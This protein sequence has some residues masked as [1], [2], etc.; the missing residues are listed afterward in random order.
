MRNDSLDDKSVRVPI[1]YRPTVKVDEAIELVRI[2]HSSLIANNVLFALYGN[3][4]YLHFFIEGRFSVHDPCC[5]SQEQATITSVI[6]TWS[7]ETGTMPV[8]GPTSSF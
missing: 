2:D 5:S 1:N 4:Y 8:A 7:I 6:T 3:S